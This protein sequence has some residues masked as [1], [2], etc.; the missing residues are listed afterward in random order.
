MLL[1][2]WERGSAWLGG[3]RLNVDIIRLE[4]LFRIPFGSCLFHRLFC[5]LRLFQEGSRAGAATT[6][7]SR[8]SVSRW[9]RCFAESG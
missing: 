8:T 4:T 9:S 1:S 3:N 7:R 5:S 2:L 6:A